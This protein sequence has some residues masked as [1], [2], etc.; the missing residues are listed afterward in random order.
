MAIDATANQ[1]TTTTSSAA[2]PPVKVAT[3]DLF[4]FKDEVVPIEVMT[5]LIFENIGGQELINIS[6]HDII[7]GQSIMYSPIKNM[8]R[9]YLQYNPQN[10]LNIQDTSA[11]YFRNYPIKLEASIP[12]PGSGPDGETVFID[13]DT[14]D[15]VIEVVNLEPDE[16]IDVQ[17]L[18]SGTLLD[19]T[20]YTG[21][22]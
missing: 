11:T 9:L 6:R 21:G 18:I 1:P 5:D 4:V 15:L 14:G 19:G 16:Q 2:N 10:I 7:S 22:I 17:V 12:S 8:S 3:P 20:I 13:P